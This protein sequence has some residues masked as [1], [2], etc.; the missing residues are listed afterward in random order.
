[1]ATELSGMENFAVGASAGTIEVTIL[2]PMLYC[3]NATQQGLPLTL[4]PMVLYRGLT[5]SIINMA[6]LTALQFPLSSMSA[7][8]ITGGASAHRPLTPV[9]EIASGFCGG[10]LSG[11]LCAP[12]ELVLIQQQRFG[13]S[14]FGT[15]FRLMSENGVFSI[16]RGLI[17]SCGREGIFTAGYIGLGPAFGAALRDNVGMDKTQSK[18]LGAVGAGVI[19]A[20]LSHPL[21]TMKTCMQGDVEQKTYKGFTHTLNALMTEGGMQRFFSGW[22]WR[23]GRMICAVG[24]MTECKERLGPLLFPNKYNKK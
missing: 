6:S 7:G 9:E 4:N 11:F 19:C 5:V 16:M 12:M 3:K 15:P 2:Q 23:T 18:M 24:I 14:I 20:T 17:P 21:D 13:G 22:A 1:M 8:L 10:A